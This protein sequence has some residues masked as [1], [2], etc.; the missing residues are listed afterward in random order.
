MWGRS[1]FGLV[2]LFQIGTRLSRVPGEHTEQ[3]EYMS[4]WPL[5]L[6][7]FAPAIHP[8]RISTISFHFSLPPSDATYNMDTNFVSYMHVPCLLSLLHTEAAGGSTGTVRQYATVP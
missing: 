1:I 5:R 7:V 3:E 4:S 6:M 8:Q 2:I